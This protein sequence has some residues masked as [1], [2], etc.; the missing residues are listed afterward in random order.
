MEAIS[1]ELRPELL[2]PALDEAR[3]HRLARLAAR[4]DGA[5]PGQWDEDLAEFNRLA[6]TTFTITDFQGIYGAEEHDTWVRRLL[7]GRCIRPAAGVTRRER[8]EVVRRAMPTNGYAD[9]EAYMAIFDANVPL[10]RASNLIFYPPDY[11]PATNTWS[12]GRPIGEYDPTPEQIVEWALAS[13]K[14]KEDAE[15]LNSL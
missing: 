8:T 7:R 5:M 3:V 10:S 9:R 15:R 11:D 1:V 2:P 13:E 6:G 12:G 4:L 14:R